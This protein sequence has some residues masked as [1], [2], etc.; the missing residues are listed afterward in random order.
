[1]DMAMAVNTGI[2][3]PPPGALAGTPVPDENGTLGK[4][5]FAILIDVSAGRVSQYIAEG[6]IDGDALV[7]TGRNQ[8]IHVETAKAQL[9]KRLDVTQMTGNGLDTKIK[10]AMVA[11]APAA[12]LSPAS[13]PQ[14]SSPPLAD[15][16]EEQIKRER[17]EELR[18]R[19]RKL[20]EEEAA[21][22]GRYVDADSVKQQLG[23]LAGQMM[24]LFEGSLPELATSLAAHFKLPQRD[25]LH[26]LRTEFNGIRGRAAPGF[27][28]SA[29]A[30]PPLV[31]GEEPAAEE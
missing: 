2:S 24:T 14:V 27:A 26:L 4:G 1:M 10:A 16:L 31:E 5:Q 20:A 19:N 28:Q 7:G 13:P 25:V 23:R 17:L 12:D 11:A 29:S 8:R 18:S 6:K 30:M 22:A 9:R 15:T 3:G 21:R